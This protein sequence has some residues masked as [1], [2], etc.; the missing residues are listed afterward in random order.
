[1]ISRKICLLGASAVG[2]TS[3]VRRFV[4]GVFDDKYLTTVGVK[5]DKRTVES[6][7]QE[8]NLILWDISGEDEFSQLQMS[9]LRGA[10]G[11]LF[12]ADGLRPAT[13]AKVIEIERRAREALGPR[14][15]VLAINKVDLEADWRLDE[16]ELE[17]LRK[18]GWK[19]FRT[20][21]LSGEGVAAAFDELASAEADALS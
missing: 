2:K 11:Y 17:T 4:H 9:Y 8:V 5:I 18:Q 6:E 19:L 21:A 13:L 3:L 1:M 12:V 15:F 7:G 10:A 20:S 16:A 14:R